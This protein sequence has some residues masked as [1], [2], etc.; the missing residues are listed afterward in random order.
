MFCATHDRANLGTDLCE[1]IGLQL[2]CIRSDAD[3]RKCDPEASH[4][5][6]SHPVLGPKTT[7]IPLDL[8]HQVL[9]TKTVRHTLLFGADDPL[10]TSSADTNR[11]PSPLR[12]LFTQIL[13]FFAGTYADVFA[14]TEGPPLH[15][16]LAVSAAIDPAIF[17]DHNGERFKVDVVTEG[18]HSITQTEVG[19]LGRTKVTKLAPGEGGCRIPRSVDLARFWESIESCMKSADAVSLMPKVSREDLVKDGVLEGVV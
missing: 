6:F 11:T 14:I 15:D 10:D 9:G 16:P 17:D 7:L 18:V 4:F 19:E 8:S 3:H 1:F 5:I 12:A 2:K 13:S